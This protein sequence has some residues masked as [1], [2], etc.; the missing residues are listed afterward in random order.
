MYSPSHILVSHTY[1]TK[2]NKKQGSSKQGSNQAREVAA[3]KQQVRALSVRKEPR[4]PRQDRNSWLGNAGMHAGNAV[5]KIFGLGAYKLKVN[6]V[7]GDMVNN[8]VPV[9]HSDSETIVLRHREYIG[10]VSS[11]TSFATTSYSV[12]PG[13]PAT[14]PYLSAV[15]QNFQ[16]YDFRGLVFEFKS[17]SADALNSTNT[18]LGTV[19]LAAQYNATDDVFVDKQQMLNEMWSIDTKPSSNVLLPIECDPKENP[20]KVQYIRTGALSTTQGSML[21][22]DLCNLVVGTY[23]SQAAAVV[24]ELW[25]TYEVELRKPKLSVGLGLT[26][27]GA[28]YRA[29]GTMPG[30]TSLFTSSANFVAAKVDDNIGLTV[31]GATFNVLNF[32][33]GCHGLYYIQMYCNGTSTALSATMTYTLSNC[34]KTSIY[35]PAGS[36]NNGDITVPFNIT[37]TSTFFGLW[38]NISD[39]T[40]AASVTYLPAV[41]N[42]LSASTASDLMVTQLNFSMLS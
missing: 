21:Q 32:P 11:T 36:S 9:M 31:S 18:A 14:F 13:L 37:T 34:T 27:P 39:P 24:G 30:Q 35:G 19:I 7:F 6:S 23:G 28:H 38:I 26:I 15:A 41:T 2:Q 5:A 4:Q 40:L 29:F 17:T 16:E 42:M 10:D 20:F 33:K 8:T 1:M 3:L 12:N 25:A 22:Y